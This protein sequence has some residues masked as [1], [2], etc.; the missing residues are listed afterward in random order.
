MLFV[1][2][3]ALQQRLLCRYGQDMCLLDATYKTCKYA[4]SLFF[5]CVKTNVGYQVVATFIQNEAK[6]DIAEALNILRNWNPHRKPS[7]FMTDKCNA[8]I[9]AVEGSGSLLIS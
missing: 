1:H 5:L 4:L 6:A 3:L 9:E 7:Y 2:E 8:E